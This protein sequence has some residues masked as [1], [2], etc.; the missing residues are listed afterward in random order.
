[1]NKTYTIK[2]LEKISSIKA[3]T[4]RIWEKRYNLL[5]PLRTDTNIRLYSEQDLKKLLMVVIL[6][7]YGMRI[8]KIS[9]LTYTRLQELVLN[10][11]I[12]SSAQTTIIE[13]LM[14][15]ITDFNQK[16]IDEIL[17]KEI[18][19][20][21]IENSFEKV[22]YPF[23]RKVEMLWLTDIISGIHYDFTFNQISRFLWQNLKFIPQS[24]FKKHYITIVPPNSHTMP[25]LI[26]TAFILNKNHN[27]ITFI[28]ATYDL[29]GLLASKKFSKNIFLTVYNY[30]Y[31]DFYKRLIN[32]DHYITLIDLSEEAEFPR[33]PNL[34]IVNKI[35]ELT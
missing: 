9:Q 19:N 26:Y 20:T 10:L 15:G 30:M 34:K 6:Y 27:K 16:F 7:K 29:S 12:P 14:L 4:I 5:K 17:T 8:S 22:I 1:M 23:L 13:Q 28:G 3:H 33:L 11:K 25:Y 31:K 35:C 21:G 32:S 18:I 24:H 2:E